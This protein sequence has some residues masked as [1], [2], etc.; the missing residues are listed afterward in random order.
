M[1]QLPR[2]PI[3]SSALS[4]GPCPIEP[5]SVHLCCAASELNASLRKGA[6]RD[7][8]LHADVGSLV[9]THDFFPSSSLQC[10]PLPIALASAPTSSQLSMGFMQSPVPDLRTWDCFSEPRLYGSYIANRGDELGTP[11]C[12]TRAALASDDRTRDSS[13][14]SRRPLW[15]AVDVEAT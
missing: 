13:R 6:G 9:S 10:P 7:S 11:G 12:N 2:Q 14:G 5:A 15:Q 4:G 3:D 1:V 8:L